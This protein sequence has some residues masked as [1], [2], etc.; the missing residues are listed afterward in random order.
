MIQALKRWRAAWRFFKVTPE[1]MALY[2]MKEYKC[3][4]AN[5]HFCKMTG[6]DLETLISNDINHFIWPED[7]NKT[8]DE[9]DEVIDN[10]EVIW[11]TLE[12]VRVFRN[13]WIHGITKEVLSMKWQTFAADDYFVCK[14][15][16]EQC[17]R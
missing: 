16:V 5:I 7:V 3:L 8:L 14:V 13:R 11:S 2:S 6:Y 15:N 9:Y 10:S 12:H 17:K 1:A 4:Y